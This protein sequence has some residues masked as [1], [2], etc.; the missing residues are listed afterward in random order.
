MT[1]SGQEI[2]GAPGLAYADEADRVTIRIAYDGGTFPDIRLD[3]MTL[4]VDPAGEQ[5]DGA[6]SAQAMT[7]DLNA[8]LAPGTALD[9][10]QGWLDEDDQALY[11]VIPKATPATAPRGAA[12]KTEA[13][14]E[15]TPPPLP[16]I[17]QE[18]VTRLLDATQND[19]VL[20]RHALDEPAEAL[21]EIGCTIPPGVT[22]MV[23]EDSEDHLHLL[24]PDPEAGQPTAA[25]RAALEEM[26]DSDPLGAA[27]ELARRDG[28]WRMRLLTETPA[29]LSEMGVE[30]PD[31]L[32][33]TAL[34]NAP[35]V[36]HLVLPPVAAEQKLQWEQEPAAAVTDA[37]EPASASLPEAQPGGSSVPEAL[38]E[39]TPEPENETA[40]PAPPAE[41]GPEP[42]PISEAGQ[43][44]SETLPVP[45]SASIDA[46][47]VPARPDTAE[48]EAALST[49]S[50]QAPFGLEVAGL[51]AALTSIGLPA[52]EAG[53][54]T[55]HTAFASRDGDL[56]FRLIAAEQDAAGRVLS[57]QLL[58]AF[59][60]GDA[61]PAERAAAFDAAYRYTKAQINGDGVVTLRLDIFLD[62]PE[63][64]GRRALEQMLEIWR[65]HLARF[66]EE[67]LGLERATT[68][69]EQTPPTVH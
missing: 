18:M 65:A 33:I 23:H 64:A 62:M 43:D 55:G 5:S 42:P 4:I 47:A 16:Q 35:H 15:A 57:A 32:R 11:A 49:P 53:T 36:M 30:L 60:V 67:L 2:P 22:I 6:L 41:P 31:D 66:A 8:L 39:P 54:E 14:A 19:L 59:A 7:V 58:A 25:D 27:L 13:A 48:Q 45:D 61:V 51:N 1:F 52:D 10:E 28:Q 12:P 56:Q 3:A 29:A 68:T 9:A 63:P 40:P 46:V 24:L 34:E 37:P 21:Q 26:R 17:D 20:R 69:A 44:P 38:S 50:A